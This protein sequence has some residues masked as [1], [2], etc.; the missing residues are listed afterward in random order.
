MQA[1]YANEILGEADLEV[2]R[3]NDRIF[4]VLESN[5]HKDFLRELRD[6]IEDCGC[7][8]PFRLVRNPNGI[9]YVHNYNTFRGYY[10]DQHCCQTETGDCFYGTVTVPLTPCL[11]LEMP[12]NC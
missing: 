2:K 8:G 12:F 1:G 7:N 3:I 5:S 9:F 6:V 4:K 11:Y 10:V